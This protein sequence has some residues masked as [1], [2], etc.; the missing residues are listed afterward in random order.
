MTARIGMQVVFRVLGRI[1]RQGL[2]P[3]LAS[4]P[5]SLKDRYRNYMNKRDSRQRYRSNQKFDAKYGVETLA[6]MEG[7]ALDVDSASLEHAVEY[8]AI[9]EE[10]F[11][12]ATTGLSIDF[13]NFTFIDYGSGKGKA[14]MLASLRPYQKL[15]G[16]EFSPVLCRICEENLAAFSSPQQKTKNIEVLCVDAL[17]YLP[18]PVPTVFFMFNPFRDSVMKGVVQ[19]IGE[20]VRSHPRPVWIAYCY[21]NW[22]SV[23][24]DTGLFETVSES[25]LH[26]LYR[27]KI[28]PE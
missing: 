14:L 19:R 18:P 25:R 17:E 26:R 23:I 15:I 24:E 2:L 12:Q 22:T 5:R 4:M 1:R 28:S 10:W 6:R 16:I 8:G 21:P 27:C 13:A 20:S 3:T 9:S 11:R 7:A